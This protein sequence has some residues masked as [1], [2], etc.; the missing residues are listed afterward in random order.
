MNENL[1]RDMPSHYG[2]GIAT[3]ASQC[4]PI[5]RSQK[6]CPFPGDYAGEGSTRPTARVISNKLFSQVL[7]I[8]FFIGD[9]IVLMMLIY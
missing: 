3:P 7:F 8:F 4:T 5:M 9:L 1:Q 6:K 2:D